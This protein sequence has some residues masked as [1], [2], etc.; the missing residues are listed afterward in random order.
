MGLEVIGMGLKASGASLLLIVSVDVQRCM[1]LKWASARIKVNWQM[2]SYTEALICLLKLLL[3][4]FNIVR[5]AFLHTYPFEER[6]V[7]SLL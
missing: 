7:R 4:F 1:Y 3:P 6:L 5:V 2:I